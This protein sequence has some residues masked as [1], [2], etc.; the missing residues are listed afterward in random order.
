MF[1]WSHARKISIRARGL[2]YWCDLLD[3]AREQGV[4]IIAPLGTP[5]AI[6]FD[7]ALCVA[8]RCFDRCIFDDY[9]LPGSVYQK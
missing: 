4:P 2:H 9:Y 6:T 8:T 7:F 1:R 5:L 3:A